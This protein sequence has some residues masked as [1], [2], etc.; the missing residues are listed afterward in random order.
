MESNV[1]LVATAN[2]EVLAFADFRPLSETVAEL[3][4]IYVLPAMQ[5]RGIGARLLKAGI[6]CFPPTT[7]FVLRVEQDNTLARRFYE[8]HGFTRTREHAEAFYGHVVHE[9][10]MTLHDPKTSPEPPRPGSNL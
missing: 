9:L 6:E 3:G 2:E 7:N 8:A 10:E 1:F 4:A 5:G